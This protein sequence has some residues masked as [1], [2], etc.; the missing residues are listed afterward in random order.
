[1][2]VEF[3]R[4]L[5]LFPRWVEEGE[6]PGLYPACAPAESRSA[7]G[8]DSSRIIE[9]SRGSGSAGGVRWLD[10]ALSRGSPFSVPTFPPL[11]FP[12]TSTREPKGQQR[13]EPSDRAAHGKVHYRSSISHSALRPRERGSPGSLLSRDVALSRS[14]STAPTRARS[15]RVKDGERRREGTRVANTLP[16]NRVCVCLCVCCVCVCGANSVEERS[17]RPGGKKARRKRQRERESEREN[18]GKR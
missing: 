5:K 12:R 10:L 6:S 15:A 4:R 18:Q 7:L 2:H 8:I 11:L 17:G 1:M 14:R 13:A 16:V 9:L 3:D